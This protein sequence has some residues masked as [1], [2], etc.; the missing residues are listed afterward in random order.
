MTSTAYTSAPSTESI[1]HKLES[2]GIAIIPGFLNPEQLR[3]MQ[4]AFGNM[5]KRMRWSNFDGYKKTEPY[6]HMVE[7]VLMLDQGFVDA[8]LDPRVQAT[9]REYVGPCDQLG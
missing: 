6:R 5:L 4:R 1:V 3:G 9:M 8:G 7:D 2:D